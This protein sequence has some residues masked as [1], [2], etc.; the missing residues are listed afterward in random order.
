MKITLKLVDVSIA[1]EIT[2][3][4]P[5][6]EDDVE[7][8]VA[9]NELFALPAKE[10]NSW[11]DFC[12]ENDMNYAD[13]KYF[14]SKITYSI[15]ANDIIHLATHIYFHNVNSY[16]TSLTVKWIAGIAK[17]K[18]KT[19]NMSDVQIDEYVDKLIDCCVVFGIVNPKKLDTYRI[20]IKDEL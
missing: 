1:N 8:M 18:I 5:V 4:I 11:Y 15:A 17:I 7:K 20:M 9:V 19:S 2:F 3:D 14:S 12:M 6:D 13:R 10:L 16:D